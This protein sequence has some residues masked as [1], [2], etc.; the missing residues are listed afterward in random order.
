MYSVLCYLQSPTNPNPTPLCTLLPAGTALNSPSLYS[1]TPYTED[2]LRS[3][4]FESDVCLCPSTQE[5]YI[6]VRHHRSC[7]CVSSAF[8]WMSVCF[9]I[10]VLC[11]Y[12]TI[13]RHLEF[14]CLLCKRFLT[15]DSG[16]CVSTQPTLSVINHP[17]R[18]SFPTLPM[19]V[20]PLDLFL[21]QKYLE[22]IVFKESKHCRMAPQWNSPH[23]ADGA[24]EPKVDPDV[25]TVYNMRC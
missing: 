17:H 2:A 7:A 11:L 16:V 15:F 9:H 14:L 13:P 18:R 3:L 12:S 23:L 10:S 22:N 5:R 19:Y 25:I 24:P 8:N 1:Q 21:R 6:F 20:V 4:C